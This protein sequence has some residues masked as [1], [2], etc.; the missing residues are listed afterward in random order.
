MRVGLERI[1]NNPHSHATLNSR[2]L[3]VRADSIRA[4]PIPCPLYLQ[5]QHVLIRCHAGDSQC[6]LGAVLCEFHDAISSSSELR[7]AGDQNLSAACALDLT[8][9][10]ILRHGLGLSGSFSLSSLRRHAVPFLHTVT[11]HE[12]RT[13]LVTTNSRGTPSCFPAT[14]NY[15]LMNFQISLSHDQAEEN[16][17]N[18]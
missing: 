3:T 11:C 7:R 1:Q 16:M 18:R 2:M 13:M 14:S 9:T 6:F 10:F 5:D 8:V 15:D 17:Q 4:S 12:P